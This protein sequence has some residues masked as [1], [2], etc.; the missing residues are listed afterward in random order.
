MKFLESAAHAILYHHERWDGGGYP[1]GKKG[2]QIPL[3]S[4]ILSI[5]DAYDAMVSRR[6][7]GK[8]MKP[9]EAIRE[10]ELGGGKQFDARLVKVFAKLLQNKKIRTPIVKPLKK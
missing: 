7:Y 10:L 3:E 8:K 9:S 4:R 2:T 6:S 5:A 1:E